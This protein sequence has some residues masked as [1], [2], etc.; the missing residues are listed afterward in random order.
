MDQA[1]TT[2]VAAEQ[3]TPQVQTSTP[4]I[5]T[6]WTPLFQGVDRAMGAAELAFDTSPVVP[7]K[8]YVNALRVDVL[9]EAVS[10]ITTPKGG[11][12]QTLGATI[13]GFLTAQPTVMVAVNANFSWYDTDSVG[14]NFALM[15]LAISQGNVV[16]DP[17]QPAKQPDM[18][19]PPPADVRDA[20]DAGA[21]AM[22]ISNTGSQNNVVQFQLVTAQNPGWPEGTHTAIAGS[23]TPVGNPTPSLNWP[24]Q[25]ATPGPL[26]LV[27]DG[28]NMGDAQANLPSPTEKLAARTAVGASQDGR[29]LY[30][31]TLDGCENADWKYGGGYYDIAQWLIIAG[32][33]Q[34]LNLDGGGSTAMAYRDPDAGPV[35]VNIPYGT[36]N[37][38]G[39][40]RAVGNY[41]GVVTTP[42]S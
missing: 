1:V 17:S 42:L 13:T 32:A 16:C 31:V 4:Y 21:M 2:A 30:L 35:L 41:F 33:Y 3:A 10:F 19:P 34:G 7:R 18:D 14:G 37:V 12:Y 29:Y 38:P 26:L 28:V 40:Q 5:F 8:Q 9:D 15:G 27:K 6:S 36:E 39:A 20:G 11:L 22:T 23:S 24:P 25:S